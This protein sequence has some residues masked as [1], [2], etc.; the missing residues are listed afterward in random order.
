MTVSPTAIDSAGVSQIGI[1]YRYITSFY[2]A[3]TTVTTVGYGDIS[4]TTWPVRPDRT[5]V[6]L[7]L[8]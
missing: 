2:W 1:S 3:L 5:R 4:A 6:R 7:Q 8:Q